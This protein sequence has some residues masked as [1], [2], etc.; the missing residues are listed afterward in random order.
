MANRAEFTP[1]L[2]LIKI[3]KEGNVTNVKITKGLSKE[4]DD[5]FVR[6]I[7]MLPKFTPGKINGLA[8][9]TTYS[10]P[11]TIQ[12][13]E[14]YG[15]SSR[16]SRSATTYNPR[17]AN[18][19]ENT[20]QEASAAEISSYFFSSS[21]LGYINCDRFLSFPDD[22]IIDYA[23]NL[24]DETDACIYVLFH[25]YKSIIRGNQTKENVVFKN[26]ASNEKI[27]IVAVKYFDSKPFLAVKETITGR[28]PENDLAFQPV[29]LEGIKEEMKK[30]NRLN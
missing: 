28:N 18:Y 30:L 20:I 9:N 23:I 14:E 22:K 12:S 8:V 24:N 7:K 11:I 4:A 1:R 3:D 6:V 5:E 15:S 16:S 19:T 13:P 2:R 17:A 26:I 21:K 27:T 10:L 25:R 29:T